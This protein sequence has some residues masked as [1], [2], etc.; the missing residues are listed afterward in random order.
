MTTVAKDCLSKEEH[1]RRVFK[2]LASRQEYVDNPY[3]FG[4]LK[5]I[6]DETWDQAVYTHNNAER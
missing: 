6:H 2:D 4:T 1:W 3:M 5:Y